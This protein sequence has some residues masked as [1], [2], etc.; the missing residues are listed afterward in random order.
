MQQNTLGLADVFIRMVLIILQISHHSIY[1]VHSD[2]MQG[3]FKE[4]LPEFTHRE[5]LGLGP[6]YCV[7]WSHD[8]WFNIIA[9]HYFRPGWNL[10]SMQT[11]DERRQ[12][13][14]R[15]CFSAWQLLTTV[16]HAKVFT[17]EARFLQRRILLSEAP[18]IPSH[19]PHPIRGGQEQL[20]SK[21]WWNCGSTQ[22][23]TWRRQNPRLQ[24]FGNKYFAIVTVC[25]PVSLSRNNSWYDR[26]QCFFS[27]LMLLDIH[28]AHS[29][30]D[31]LIFLSYRS[32]N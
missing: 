3:S 6:Q 7:I 25:L 28:I 21:W 4:L 27:C 18:W 14:H 20:E 23:S 13:V 17:K 9:V 10:W 8:V 2:T 24:N 30:E 15:L 26:V 12:S 16:Q 31:I 22:G 29:E 19:W 1:H 11:Q 32:W 5:L